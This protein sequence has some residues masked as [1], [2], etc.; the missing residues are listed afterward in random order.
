MI[1]PRKQAD[2]HSEY[3]GPL[4]AA[5][6]SRLRDAVEN[7]VDV[8]A[9]VNFGRDHQHRMQIQ[10]VADCNVS[11]ICQRCLQP[12][13][14]EIKAEIDAILV[15]SEERAKALPQDLD[16]WVVG[17]TANLHELIE[18]E[19]LLALPIVAYHPIDDVRCK[20]PAIIETTDGSD[21]APVESE[22]P[23]ALLRALKTEQEN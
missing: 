11:M 21:L 8:Q 7:I 17:E 9:T 10:G 19:L 6:L 18:D 4:Q 2:Q 16:A 20:P 3:Q 23:F 14:Q 1:D 13:N 22:S 12:S 15:F 5:E